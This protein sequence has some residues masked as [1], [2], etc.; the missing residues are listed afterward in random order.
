MLLGPIRATLLALVVMTGAA[1]SGAWADPLTDFNAAVE[2]AAS[3]NRGA[4]G[5][6]RTGNVDLAELE[7]D[8]LRE[9]WR[10]LTTR[11]AGQRPEAFAGNPLYGPLW[12][13]VSARLVA[14]DM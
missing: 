13:G 5:Y 12:T 8:R 7:I 2:T 3:H 11:F 14:A 9:S 1:I 10:E 4:I 6:L